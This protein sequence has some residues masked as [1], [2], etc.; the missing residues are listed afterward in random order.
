MIQGR[1]YMERKVRTILS[2]AVSAILV[3][4]I[5]FA[6]LQLKSS[7]ASNAQLSELTTGYATF[8]VQTE[9]I[10][11]TSAPINITFTYR[12][13]NISLTFAQPHSMDPAE[14]RFYITNQ[15]HE[16][17]LPNGSLSPGIYA[18]YEVGFYPYGWFS[19]WGQTIVPIYAGIMT[20]P[21]GNVVCGHLVDGTEVNDSF[22]QSGAVLTF[23]FMPGLPSIQGYVISAIYNGSS[24]ASIMLADRV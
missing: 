20:N 19:I 21:D 6:S 11:I 5:L 8:V 9:I 15:S 3:L 13:V 17:K 22:V 1:I 4:W 14:L 7:I 24:I 23:F 2:I 18:D 12:F 16:M 10:S